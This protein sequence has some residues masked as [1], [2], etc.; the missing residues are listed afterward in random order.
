MA[1]KDAAEKILEA[2]DDVFCDIA[3]VLLFNGKGILSENDIENSSHKSY[4]RTDGR[5]HELE[6]D[7]AKYYKKG[8]ITIATIGIENQTQP[9]GNM[10][11]RVIG[12]DGSE[13][14]AQLLNNNQG[15]SCHPVITIVLYFGYRHR[16]K[17]NLSLKERLHIP[18][19]LA[20]YVNDYKINLFQIAYLTSEQVSLFK[21][22]FRI[23]ADYF[24][25]KR[26]HYEACIKAKSL[27]QQH[28]LQHI[29]HLLYL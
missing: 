25:H 5:I 26:E 13:Y 19:E 7:I 17:K 22:D 20:P 8:K 1:D 3:N 12:Y 4:Y 16:W 21:S 24:V 28:R 29:H 15:N 27:T 18:E 23:I 2:Y 14:R 9:D 10:P 6:R 11:L